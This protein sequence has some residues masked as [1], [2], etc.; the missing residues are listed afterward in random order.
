MNCVRCG[1]KIEKCE[2][3]V[4]LEDGR[5]FDEECFFHYSVDKLGGIIRKRRFFRTGKWYSVGSPMLIL[6]TLSLY[7][8]I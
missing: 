7:N 3:Y 2:Y 1:R 8:T 4:E 6:F 5:I